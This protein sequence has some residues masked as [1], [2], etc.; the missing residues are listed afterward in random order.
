[1]VHDQAVAP[2]ERD[3]RI[4]IDALRELLTELRGTAALATP[5]PVGIPAAANAPSAEG[6][7][8]SQKITVINKIPPTLLNVLEEQFKL[9]HGW[10]E[11]I[12]KAT[13]AQSADLQELKEL[14][15]TCLAHYSKLLDG[16]EQAR[17]QSER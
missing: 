15:N 12:F 7:G 2:G 11:P 14:L 16:L 13:H 4:G 1:V 10:M 3:P 17:A 9:M 5:S 6:N 8:N